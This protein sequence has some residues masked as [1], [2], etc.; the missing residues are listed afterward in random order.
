ME[1]VSSELIIIDAGNTSIKIAHFFGADALN[2]VRVNADLLANFLNDSTWSKNTTCVLSSVAN[3]DIQRALEAY[4]N[5]VIVL[6]SNA[7]LPFINNYQ[8]D[9]L[10]MDRACNAAAICKLNPNKKSVS[11]DIGTCIKFDFVDENATYFGGSISPG[12]HLRYK[13]LNDYTA[14]LPLLNYYEKT[15]LIG[16]S[17]EK[18]IHSG[19][20]NGMQAE[21]ND[22]IRQYENKYGDLTFF[23]TGG[24][25]KY[26]DFDRK[27]NIFA[28]ENLTLLG[29]YY[30]Y[31]QNVQ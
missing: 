16:N 1:T 17:T 29:I 5:K 12:I 2:V 10:G 8:S 18:S 7:K 28:N 22:M 4:F 6:D 26:F 15:D 25:A 9:T 14:K 31:Q 21:I 3:G 30:V 27:N 24:D 20:I 23:M 11:I 13:S 19:V